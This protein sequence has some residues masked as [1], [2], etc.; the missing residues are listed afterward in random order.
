M[1][2]FFKNG[3]FAIDSIIPEIRKDFFNACCR[4]NLKFVN[5]L[6]QKVV[7]FNGL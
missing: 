4:K 1:N 3:K 2:A 7:K 5:L 6:I